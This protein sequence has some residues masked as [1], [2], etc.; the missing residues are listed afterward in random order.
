VAENLNNKGFYIGCHCFLDK[1]DLDYVVDTFKN[2]FK[3]EIF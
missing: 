2:Y 3:D 1:D